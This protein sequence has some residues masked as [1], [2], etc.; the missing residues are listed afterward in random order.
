MKTKMSGTKV[1]KNGKITKSGWIS[2][3]SPVLTINREDIVTEH[4]RTE[5][6]KAE[7]DLLNKLL[8][9]HK[10]RILTETLIA[11]GN[12][13]N[14]GYLEDLIENI[15]LGV[16]SHLRPLLRVF[17]SD[18]AYTIG[19]ALISFVPLSFK[20]EFLIWG[21]KFD[22][23][24]AK[25]DVITRFNGI[26]EIR[27]G[28]QRKIYFFE[29]NERASVFYELPHVVYVHEQFRNNIH[30]PARLS[31]AYFEEYKDLLLEDRLGNVLFIRI[32]PDDVK[33]ARES[34]LPEW[35]GQLKI[36]QGHVLTDGRNYY[37]KGGGVDIVA[38]H[39][40]CGLLDLFPGAYKLEPVQFL[41][42]QD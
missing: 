23:T 21:I 32:C 13:R 37:V 19:K 6:S 18:R 35:T 30:P 11:L 10:L 38:Y 12:R 28:K 2:F 27:L 26:T 24:K 8:D 3:S 14:I 20:A 39:P 33:D 29:K 34:E 40:E 17:I 41:H 42:P 22:I 15:D 36:L 16:W 9:E 1:F 4:L 31:P 5:L 25:P 7:K